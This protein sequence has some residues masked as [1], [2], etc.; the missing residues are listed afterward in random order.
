MS[1]GNAIIIAT[2]GVLAL[3]A[4][5]VIGICLYS[6]RQSVYLSS[7]MWVAIVT[8][9]GMAVVVLIAGLMTAPLGNAQ[10]EESVRHLEESQRILQ[11]EI[12][13]IEGLINAPMAD[14]TDQPSDLNGL[15]ATIDRLTI[16]LATIEAPDLAAVVGASENLQSDLPKTPLSFQPP[17]TLIDVLLLAVY[18]GFLAFL[19]RA[20]DKDERFAKWSKRVK[21]ATLVFGFLGAS[22]VFAKQFFEA[23]AAF[24]KVDGVTQIVSLVPIPSEPVSLSVPIFQLRL[25]DGMTRLVIPFKAEGGCIE[26][27]PSKGVNLSKEFEGSLKWFGENLASC[28]GN[29]DKVV[30]RVRGYASSSI[31]KQASLEACRAQS[32]Q[33]AN[34]KFAERRRQNV[35]RVLAEA[36]GEKC[37]FLDGSWPDYDAM[38]AARR[39][40]DR[41]ATGYL[42]ARGMLNR[43]AE[44]IIENAADCEI[45]GADNR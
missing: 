38:V 37:V 12:G 27:E 29:G 13:R 43:R 16:Q 39:F 33:D 36:C 31:V 34:M 11:R 5:V 24:N 18:L 44:V 25:V 26:G 19:W 32:E 42:E 45:L 21:Y 15:A 1:A 40:N 10:L 28:V 23:W 14:Q 41:T 8:L 7:R 2:S 30:L 4:L 22:V 3:L 6:W 9:A 20:A 35:Q 17:T